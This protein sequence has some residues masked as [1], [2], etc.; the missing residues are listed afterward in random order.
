MNLAAGLS[1]IGAGSLGV[2]SVLYSLVGILGIG[3]VLTAY[4][5]N[6]SDTTNNVVSYTAS[7]QGTWDVVMSALFIESHLTGDRLLTFDENRASDLNGS[8]PFDAHKVATYWQDRRTSLNNI[9][10]AA[11]VY[12]SYDMA[13][14]PFPNGPIPAAIR[15]WTNF[16]YYFPG[17]KQIPMGQGP[18]LP[19]DM[20]VWEGGEFGH[21]AI[22]VAVNSAQGNTPA[23]VVV[24]QANAPARDLDPNPNKGY[25]TFVT[26]NAQWI[27]WLTAPGVHLTEFDMTSDYQVRS[28]PGYPIKGFIRNP[29]LLIDGQSGPTGNAN[30]PAGVNVTLP[31]GLNSPY[32][33]VAQQAAKKYN[34]N[35]ILFIRQINAE[36]GFNP[37][38]KSPAGALGIAQFMPATA[39]GMGVDPWDPQQ[40][41]D[42]AARMN[43]AN[44]QKYRQQGLSDLEAYK[45]MLASYN[46]GSGA[47]NQFVSTYGN[48]WLNHIY[49]ETRNYVNSIMGL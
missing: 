18:P 46:A 31:Q 27:S 35:E 26:P 9:Q 11:F 48:N 32:V 34:I 17:W 3:T 40:A 1:K 19:G 36:S 30:L 23:N 16:D 44:L 37:K 43:A 5:N 7:G 10:C 8:V 22:V 13:G 33:S 41:L 38:A 21:V 25:N 2:H 28:W 29:K 42:G 49:V 15:Y 14:H 24:A 12:T 20:I 47:V 4:N 39:A 45:R 6:T